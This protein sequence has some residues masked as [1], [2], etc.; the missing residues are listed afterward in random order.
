MI[1]FDLS[2]TGSPEC[3][4]FSDFSSFLIQTLTN[5]FL[6]CI[7]LKPKGTWTREGKSLNHFV[8]LSLLLWLAKGSALKR[9]RG[10]GENAESEGKPPHEC[11]RLDWNSQ[12]MP[13]AL[14][15]IV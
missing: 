12:N 14:T 5:D 8:V 9:K 3:L 13:L 1:A 7:P 11:F 6:T 15:S 10:K 4:T 2:D